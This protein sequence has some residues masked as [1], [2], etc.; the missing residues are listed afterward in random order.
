M[1]RSSLHM[2]QIKVH[3]VGKSVR[4]LKKNENENKIIK[5]SHEEKTY[6][7]AHTKERLSDY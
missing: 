6:L 7:T 2:F 1:D 5:Q 3:N 4:A